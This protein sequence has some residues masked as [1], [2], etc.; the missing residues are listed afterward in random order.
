MR[1][2]KLK[3]LSV[4]GCLALSACASGPQTPVDYV[5]V[6]ER[7]TGTLPCQDCR[8]VD[9]DLILKRDPITGAPAGFYL[10]EIRIDA[11]GGERV[12]TAWG[13]WAL[14]RDVNDFQR[15]LYALQPE[16]GQTRIFQPVD[17]SALEPLDAQGE[18]VRDSEGEPARLE[19]QTPD[20]ALANS[21]ADD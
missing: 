1:T 14:H 7:F 12:N 6:T 16:V 15:Q 20:L 5:K 8:G 10:H 13:K 4:V 17:G 18:P 19:R 3:R 2:S 9:T 21:A 11:P